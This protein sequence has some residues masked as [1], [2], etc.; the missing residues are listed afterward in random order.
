MRIGLFTDSYPPFINGVSTSVAMLKKALEKKGHTV[1]VVTVS[2]NALKFEIDNENNIIKIPGIPIGIYDYRISRI[3]P[4]SMINTMKNWKLDV[5]HSHTEFGIGIFAR[6]FAK[7]FNIP[8]VHTYH[9][10]YEDYTHYITHGYFDKSSKKIVEY[11]TKFYCDKTAKELIVPTNKI[12]NLFKEKYKFEKSIHIIPTGIEVDRFFEE[13]VDKKEVATLGK[14]IGLSKKDYVIIFVG[15]L[16]EEK[17]V[18]F[19]LKSQKNLQNKIPNLK[20][21]IVGDGPDKEK[22]EK[23]SKEYNIDKSTIFTG[24][25]SWEEIPLYYHNA[26]LFATAS[27]TETQGLTVIEAM[28]SSVPALCI[29]DESFKGTV[30]D[31]LNGKIFKNNTEYE[32]DVLELYKSKDIKKYK[33]QARI[34]AEHYSSSAYAERVLEVYKRAIKEKEEKQNRNIIRKIVNKVKDKKNA[35]SFK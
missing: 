18:E 8:L 25:A 13:N 29:D 34:Q 1:Y 6:L 12:Y 16:A 7:Q 2:A 17:N 22:Y 28:A 10:L 26:N 27:T 15:R 5:I 9:T 24:K 31:N 19:L 33:E 32:N 20:L 35:N 30:I 3:Y 21:L 14:K 11:L 4:I 23:L